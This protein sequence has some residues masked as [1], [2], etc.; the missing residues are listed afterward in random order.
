MFD[1]LAI[2]ISESEFGIESGKIMKMRMMRV[3]CTQQPD[4]FTFI[5]SSLPPRRGG[6]THAHVT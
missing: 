2:L 4:N 3:K 1:W 6:F 5:A